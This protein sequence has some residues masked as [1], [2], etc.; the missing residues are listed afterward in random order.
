MYKA[1]LTVTFL[2]A[3]STLKA[4]ST[5]DC[6]PQAVGAGIAKKFNGKWNT[7]SVRAWE[8]EGE[9]WSLPYQG[10][11]S[12]LAAYIKEGFAANCDVL[13]GDV[14]GFT[15]R[16]LPKGKRVDI[17]KER[18]ALQSSNEWLSEPQ[19]TSGIISD[20]GSTL[21]FFSPGQ[22]EAI[23]ILYPAKIAAA[24]ARG[25]GVAKYSPLRQTVTKIP[26]ELDIEYNFGK[27]KV[28]I[29]GGTGKASMH[30]A[31]AAV[32]ADL[33][34]FGYSPMAGSQKAV[35][36]LQGWFPPD[37]HES[38]WAHGGGIARVEFQRLKNGL[39][40]VDVHETQELQ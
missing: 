17:E 15:A 29:F 31:S 4:A 33:R 32:F 14:G 25:Q 37:V 35:E 1:A 22:N 27:V 6:Q 18:Q 28:S 11:V 2:I 24:I 39:T 12:D 21:G 26:Q 38:Y 8:Q 20:Q 5:E 10:K 9:F 40:K 36:A 13:I 23:L 3:A 16:I 19:S 34:S 7:G 30:D